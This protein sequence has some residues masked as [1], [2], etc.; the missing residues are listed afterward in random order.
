MKLL[1]ENW[2]QYVN[3]EYC[4]VCVEEQQIEEEKKPM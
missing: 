3:E 4:P 2:R 1:F